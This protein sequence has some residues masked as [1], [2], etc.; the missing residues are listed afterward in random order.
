M[1]CV[2]GTNRSATVVMAYLMRDR[3]LT[4]EDAYGEVKS[5]RKVVDLSTTLINL[6]QKYE[7]HLKKSSRKKTH[8]H[9]NTV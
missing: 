3:R 1:H 6:L 2:A 4:H 9:L 8:S 7:N 5:R